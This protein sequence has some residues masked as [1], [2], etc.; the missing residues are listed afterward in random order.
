MAALPA[1]VRAL[2]VKED[3]TPAPAG[4]VSSSST[5]WN[6]HAA[7]GCR[8]TERFVRTGLERGLTLVRSRT[9]FGAGS[10]AFGAARF[11]AAQHTACPGPCALEALG[12]EIVAAAISVGVP[13]AYARRA[14]LNGHQAPTG[15][16]A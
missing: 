5:P 3:T 2:V 7:T 4:V 1:A 13:E 15:R 12:E 14:V 6:R 11:L 8:H 10:Q 16:A 9:E